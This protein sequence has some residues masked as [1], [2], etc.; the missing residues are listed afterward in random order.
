MSEKTL[1]FLRDY[2]GRW[3]RS[4]QMLPLYALAPLTMS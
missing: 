2:P 3:S 1:V 4:A